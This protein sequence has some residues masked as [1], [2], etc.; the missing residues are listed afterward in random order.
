MGTIKFEPSPEKNVIKRGIKNQ[1]ILL[2]FL[3]M[4]I[5]S[6]LEE[7]TEGIEE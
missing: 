1:Y 5:M 6:K 7:L 2:F 3:V 4:T